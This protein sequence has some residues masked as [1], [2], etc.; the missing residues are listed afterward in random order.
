MNHEEA[1]TI[2][3]ALK[4]AGYRVQIMV[5]VDEPQETCFSILAEMREPENEAWM[6]I[7]LRNTSNIATLGLMVA[8]MQE[9]LKEQEEEPL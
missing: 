5:D 9:N 1:Q 3:L 8:K 6:F 7:H 2:G 4:N